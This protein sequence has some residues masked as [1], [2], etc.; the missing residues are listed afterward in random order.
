MEGP[1]SKDARALLTM[2]NSLILTEATTSSDSL[3]FE[4]NI[5]VECAAN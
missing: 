5:T 2:E 1:L 3:A 4:V